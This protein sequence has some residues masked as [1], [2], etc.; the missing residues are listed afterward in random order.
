MNVVSVI[1]SLDLTFA[2]FFFFFLS[3]KNDSFIM[4]TVSFPQG[5]IFVVDSN[6]RERVAESAEELSKMVSFST[7]TPQTHTV[8]GVLTNAVLLH[9]LCMYSCRKMS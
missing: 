3:F 7:G 5:L 4:F 9:F 2:F 6:D 8:A 1:F